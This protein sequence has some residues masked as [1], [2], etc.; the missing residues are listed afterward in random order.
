MMYQ[1]MAQADLYANMLSIAEGAH[2][3][4]IHSSKLKVDYHYHDS[5]DPNTKD[6]ETFTFPRRTLADKTDICPPRIDCNADA[7]LASKLDIPK[8]YY[9]RMVSKQPELWQTTCNT[10][11]SKLNKP[12]M[13]R[14]WTN[15]NG[16]RALRAILSNRY[17]RI[18][19]L[20]IFKTVLPILN[21]QPKMK[22]VSAHVDEHN[23]HLKAVFPEIEGDI[24]L[25]DVVQSGL[26]IRNSETGNGAFVIQ[27][28][29]YRL[30]CLNGMIIPDAALRRTHLGSRIEEGQDINWRDETIAA[31]DKA[32]MMKI[33]DVTRQAT[34]E[35]R[36]TYIVEQLKESAERTIEVS[37]MEQVKIL[38][39]KQGLTEQEHNTILEFLHKSDGNTHWDVANAVTSAAGVANDYAQATNLETLGG[40]IATTPQLLA[41]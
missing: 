23:F 13:L 31:D 16:R 25:N 1:G 30:V 15:R 6:P 7:Q 41:A 36:F 38:T 14:Q 3:E 33:E 2:D 37:K 20:D 22:I 4:I 18:D 40:K 26:H 39:K 29:T 5:F 11:L 34:D 21:E 32:L 10:W 9:D 27:P 19:N 12:L 35:S 28:L 24:G 17:R 8:A